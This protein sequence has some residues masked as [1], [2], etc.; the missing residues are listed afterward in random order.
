MIHEF[1]AEESV[2]SVQL[3]K[4]KQDNAT[5][6]MSNVDLNHVVMISLATSYKNC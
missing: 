1:I 5:R 4:G 3:A 6:C 2:D